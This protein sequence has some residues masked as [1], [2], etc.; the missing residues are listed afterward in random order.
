[1]YFKRSIAVSVG[2]QY[3]PS[4]HTFVSIKTLLVLVFTWYKKFWCA[5]L[6][7]VNFLYNLK[8]IESIKFLFER[9]FMW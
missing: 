4:Y 3:F 2:Q 6:G 7:A 9:E 1:M 8:V 5:P